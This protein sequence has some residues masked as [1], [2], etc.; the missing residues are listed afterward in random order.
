MN[1]LA[2]LFRK[3]DRA[4]NHAP[5]AANVEPD[6]TEDLFELARRG[7]KPRDW[8]PTT[9]AERAN[10]NR[11]AAARKAEWYDAGPTDKEIEAANRDLRATL[12]GRSAFFTTGGASG[13]HSA[14]QEPKPKPPQYRAVDDAVLRDDIRALIVRALAAGHT[15]D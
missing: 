15:L 3:T 1:L 10:L 8:Y 12:E 7:E 13:G 4:N 11:E 5:R 2:R 6:V 9:A 14:A